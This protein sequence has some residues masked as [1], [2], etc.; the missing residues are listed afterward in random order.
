VRDKPGRLLCIGVI[1]LTEPLAHLPLLGDWQGPYIR[2]TME[3]ID[4]ISRGGH[5]S[6]KP[7]RIITRAMYCA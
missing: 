1:R 4:R 2:S 3:N 7:S 6:R 5:C